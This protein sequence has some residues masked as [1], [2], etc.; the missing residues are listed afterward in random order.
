M[1]TSSSGDS[2]V[3]GRPTRSFRAPH[4]FAAAS[5]FVR[6]EDVAASIP[7]GDN[8]DAF[9]DAVRSYTEAGFTEVAL[10]QVGGDTQRPFLDW[11]EKELLP[12]LREL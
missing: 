5:Q 6:P 12:A 3:A 7:C 2:A 1:H 8:V 11:A 4:S 10:V 9:V